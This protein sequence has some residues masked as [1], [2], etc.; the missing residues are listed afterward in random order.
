MPVS[1]VARQQSEL[2]TVSPDA[3]VQEVADLMHREGV[4]SI[5]VV[6]ENEPVG[7]VTDRD[8]ALDIIPEGRDFAGMTA[9]DVMARDPV[10]VN[11]N[12]GVLEACRLM[13][14]R[15]IRR[16]PVVEDGE[17]VGIVTLDDLIVLLDDE[18][19]DLSEVIR[20]ESPPWEPA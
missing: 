19:S 1:S 7:I 18:M 12:E 6:R 13:R 2:V 15:S 14:E 5:I 20:A 4:G 10:T 8:L 3:P 9:R 11:A 17:L 16:L